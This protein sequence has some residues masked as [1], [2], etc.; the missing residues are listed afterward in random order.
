MIIF[1][2]GFRR[3]GAPSL[4][5]PAVTTNLLKL[6]AHFSVSHAMNVHARGA[7]IRGRSPA[8]AD[9]SPAACWTGSNRRRRSSQES[10]S[11]FFARSRTTAMGSFADR[12]LLGSLRHPR[13]FWPDKTTPALRL[14]SRTRISATS[15]AH[16]YGPISFSFLRRRERATL[17]VFAVQI[18]S[19]RLRPPTELESIGYGPCR[20]N[21]VTNLFGER[22]KLTPPLPCRVAE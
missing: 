3:A 20:A 16:G 12:Q 7:S 8:P 9:L 18:R 15:P 4:R 2:R 19:Y 13:A 11:D 14:V 5:A 17:P 10:S 22:Q 21:L 6:G 1:G